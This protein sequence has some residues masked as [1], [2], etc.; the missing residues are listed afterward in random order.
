MNEEQERTLETLLSAIEEALPPV[1]FRNWPKWRDI[2]PISPR[3]VANDD[4]RGVGP[5]EKMFLG[6]V[7]GYSR[8]SFMEYLRKKTRIARTDVNFI[9]QQVSSN[10]IRKGS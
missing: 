8:A 4:S 2:I 1:I 7:A 10:I 9:A 5:E 6:R 3:S